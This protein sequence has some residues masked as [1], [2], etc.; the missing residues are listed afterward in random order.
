ME[1]S[2]RE[3]LMARPLCPAP[4]TMVVVFSIEGLLLDVGWSGHVDGDV[5]GVG[6]DV[7]NGRAFLRLRD[8]GLDLLRG[9]V[10]VD[11]VAH[12]DTGEAVA[13]LAVGTQD[14]TDILVRLD[15]GLP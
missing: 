13:D 7:V 5:G 12:P 9:C 1:R 11:L 2:A 14:S 3:R 15:S 4:T 10:S 8:Q 6:E